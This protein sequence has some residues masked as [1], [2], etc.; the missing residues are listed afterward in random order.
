MLFVYAKIEKIMPYTLPSVL[1]FC[2]GVK[3]AVRINLY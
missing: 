1:K 3:E 2:D